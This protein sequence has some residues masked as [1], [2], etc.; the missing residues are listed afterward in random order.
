MKTKTSIRGRLLRL[1]IMCAAVMGF[2]LAFA[3]TYAL[4]LEIMESSET[5]DEYIAKN[6]SAVLSE[7]VEFIGGAISD[8]EISE[9]SDDIFNRVFL[10]GTDTGYDYSSFSE[11][12]K[13]IDAETL[14]FSPVLTDKTGNSIILAGYKA[15]DAVIKIGEISYVYFA[16][17]LDMFNLN[18]TSGGL[19]LD[20][21]GQILMTNE[22][23]AYSVGGTLLEYDLNGLLSEASKGGIDTL[24]EKSS[25]TGGTRYFFSYAEVSGTDYFSVYF[26]DYELVIAKYYNLLLIMIGVYIVMLAITVLVSLFVARR[27]SEPLTVVTNRLVALSNGDVKT[28]FKR[29]D[30]NDETQILSEAMTSTISTLSSYIGDIQCVLSGISAGNL[31]VKSDVAY[32]GDFSEIHDS[33]DEISASLNGIIKTIQ[34]SGS[35]FDEGA[36]VVAEGAKALADNTAEEASTLESIS[37]LI[38]NIRAAI[39]GNSAVTEKADE[40]SS[41]IRESISAGSRNMSEMSVA[42]GEIKEASDKI[43]S[44]VKII[45]D[46]AFQ[47]NILALNAAVEA[48]R[49][50]EAGKGFAVVADEVRNLAAKSAEAV[51]ST[52]ILVSATARAVE[53]GAGLAESAGESFAEIEKNMNE[54]GNLVSS[55]ASACDGQKYAI[56]EIDSGIGAMTC[57]V[58]QNSATAEESAAASDEL[59]ES[60]ADLSEKVKYFRTH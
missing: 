47:T 8:R 12:C 11:K 5:L 17:M 4:Y 33:L 7:E 35:R 46:I 10:N 20:S 51:K 23:Y 18:S 1:G 19:I 53:K 41:G 3:G 59:R 24:V 22:N 25:L 26:S 48:A 32:K 58:T 9:E 16:S 13:G 36:A 52:E 57:A 50:G 54:F 34:L 14:C 37:V 56:S 21:S 39:E 49:A 27:V 44:I 15:T 45:N 42:V 60:A 31:T 40:L 30:T 38:S 55:I 43:Q 28:P 29:L 6:V 2:V